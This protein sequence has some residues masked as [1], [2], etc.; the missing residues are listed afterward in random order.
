MAQEFDLNRPDYRG[1]FHVPIT[2]KAG[3]EIEGQFS[4]SPARALA[5]ALAG[6]GVK[7][8]Y[9]DL[10]QVVTEA[11]VKATFASISTKETQLSDKYTLYHP[12]DRNS[13]VFEV[14]IAVVARA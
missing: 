7:C 10:T 14:N 4:G 6:R 8:R 11:D 9:G 13:L 3:P 1:V 5:S 12:A 2:Y